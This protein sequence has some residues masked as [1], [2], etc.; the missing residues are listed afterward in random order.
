MSK[1]FLITS[2]TA[3]SYPFEQ[4]TM[5]SGLVK[6]LKHHFPDCFVV[7]AS[8]SPVDSETQQLS[9]FVIV[10]QVSSNVPHGAGELALLQQGCD[11]LKRFNKTEYFKLCYDF[12]I[13]STN[14]GVFDRMISHGKDFVSCY[15]KTV[16]L[17]IGTWIWYSTIAI[18]EQLFDFTDLS[19]HLEWKLLE[20]VQTKALLD[21]CY[22][23][24]DQTSMFNGD[25]YN[26]CDLVHSG[27][28]V[29]KH[30]YGTISA[31]VE[32]SDA[33]QSIA[34]AVLASVAYQSKLPAHLVLVDRR[35]IKTDLRSV[36]IFRQLFEL[37]ERKGTSWS[38][39]YYESQSQVKQYLE[40]LGHT[41]CMLIDSNRLLQEN[42]VKRFYE[43]VILNYDVGLVM[44]QHQTVLYRNKVLIDTEKIYDLRNFVV[45]NMRNTCYNIINS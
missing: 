2:H 3:G 7:V 5:L 45:D 34:P 30:S 33:S 4:R 21:R 43:T 1:S 15:W 20:V 11:V 36:D 23:Y 10:D 25:W 17:G 39:I 13:D 26:R 6:S 35:E 31:V 19:Y 12:V 40:D 38:L 22:L 28:T 27:G 37:L 9:D 24:D 41:W 14:I 42:S 18:H 29:L 8:Q 16:D 44:D 32:I